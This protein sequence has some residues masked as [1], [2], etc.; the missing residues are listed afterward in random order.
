M[1]SIINYDE[2][3][4]AL[5]ERMNQEIVKAVE[6]VIHKAVADAEKEIR[7][8]IGEM[9]ISLLETS[10]DARRDGRELLIRVEL[11]GK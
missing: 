6:P 10:Y 1:A 7:K 11:G 9:A 3:V 2:L 8:R 4:K 5:K